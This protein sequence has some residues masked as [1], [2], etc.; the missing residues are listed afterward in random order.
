[1]PSCTSSRRTERNFDI[2]DTSLK[3]MQVIG[4][5]RRAGC[6]CVQVKTYEE[7]EQ[8]F[9]E[10][11]SLVQQLKAENAALQKDAKAVAG[12]KAEVA[13]LKNQVRSYLILHT[14]LT[15]L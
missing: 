8:H 13:D 3:A 1:M 5:S 2:L 9:R 4:G 14:T 15:S 12:L 6:D 7:A 10:Q 11:K